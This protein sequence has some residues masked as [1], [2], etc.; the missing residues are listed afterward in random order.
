MIDVKMP[1]RTPLSLPRR[2]L[3]SKPQRP[4]PLIIVMKYPS[5]SSEEV[6]PFETLAYSM[7]NV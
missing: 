1:R 7:E 6:T 2:R 4:K 3:S 5:L